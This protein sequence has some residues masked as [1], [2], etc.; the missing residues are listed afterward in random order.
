MLL[1]QNNLICQ[2]IMLINFLK[3]SYGSSSENADLNNGNLKGGYIAG[4][5]NGYYA[6]ESIE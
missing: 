3:G 4:M 1:Y 6:K 5:P 2:N